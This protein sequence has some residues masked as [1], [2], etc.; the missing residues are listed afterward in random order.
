MAA[1]EVLGAVLGDC[2]FAFGFSVDMQQR[3][4][5]Q[6]WD[7]DCV[8]IVYPKVIHFFSLTN[9]SVRSHRGTT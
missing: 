6:M 9:G 5:D 2:W 8:E 1:R 4:V 7:T 3:G